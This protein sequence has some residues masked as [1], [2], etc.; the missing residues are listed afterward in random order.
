MNRAFHWQTWSNSKKGKSSSSLIMVF[1]PLQIRKSFT[2]LV[3]DLNASLPSVYERDF[4]FVLITYFTKTSRVV[5]L[6]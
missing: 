6:L 4:V 2:G 3:A 5:L 1:R